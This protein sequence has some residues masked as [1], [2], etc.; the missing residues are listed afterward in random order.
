MAQKAKTALALG[1]FDGIHKGHKAV[2]ACALSK[3]ERGLIPL[4]MLF[5]AH[6]LLALTGKAPDML[7]QDDLRTEMLENTGAKAEVISFPK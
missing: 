5:D 7:L 6:P 4:V 2:I 3:K 1:T